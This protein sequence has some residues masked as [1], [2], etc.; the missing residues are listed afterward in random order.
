MRSSE[1]LDWKLRQATGV[2]KAGF[3]AD[4]VKLLVESGEKVVLYGWHLDVY[5][6]WKE[7]LADLKP[8]FY[9]GSES[10]PQKEESRRRF[11]AGE[12]Q[13][14]IMSLRAGAGLDGLQGVCRNVVFGELDWSPM[15]HEQAIGRVHRDGQAEQV[16]AYF[17]VAEAGSDPIVADVLGLKKSQI[18]GILDLEAQLEHVDTAGDRMKKLARALLL[19]LGETVPEEAAPVVPTTAPIDDL[20]ADF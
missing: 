14:L 5:A 8:A 4:F 18:R 13:V 1:E 12:T 7:R 6:I 10:T 19:R 20:P 16:M 2:A 11:I 3:V 17:L 9:T 15:V